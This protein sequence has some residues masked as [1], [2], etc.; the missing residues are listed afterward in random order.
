MIMTGSGLNSDDRNHG[1]VARGRSRAT[2]ITVS[3]RE[4]NGDNVRGRSLFRGGRPSEAPQSC[5]DVVGSDKVNS[6]SYSNSSNK[7]NPTVRATELSSIRMKVERMN[8]K[9]SVRCASPAS[10]AR[11]PSRHGSMCGGDMK[12]VGS[13]SSLNSVHTAHSSHGVRSRQGSINSVH[14]VNLYDDGIAGGS[15]SLYPGHRRSVFEANQRDKDKIAY[16]NGLNQGRRSI[17]FA[18][19]N[20]EDYTYASRLYNP[21]PVVEEKQPVF[22]PAYLA[23]DY[24]KN[25]FQPAKRPVLGRRSNTTSSGFEE[26]PRSKLNRVFSHADNPMFRKGSEYDSDNDDG[27]DDNDNENDDND[28]DNN[29]TDSGILVDVESIQKQL[30]QMQ[31]SSSTDAD[32]RTNYGGNA[33]RTQ[34]SQYA[35]RMKQQTESG[36]STGD[37]AAFGYG[38]Y[39]N[40][41]LIATRRQHEQTAQALLQLSVQGLRPFVASVERTQNVLRKTTSTKNGSNMKM[42][43]KMDMA[44][45]MKSALSHL[46]KAALHQHGLSTT[47]SALG[48]T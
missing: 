7:E 1:Q 27:T 2:H 48:T 23:S 35:M 37:T 39:V 26:I 5:S 25:A 4:E 24:T 32:G 43:M 15:G 3:S 9:T 13:T 8:S 31:L 21:N 30:S 36:V 22:R 29:S 11:I 17:D 44:A 34:Q 40:A 16:L 45:N 46:W 12:R 33:M 28:D 19:T 42:D 20:G 41:Q 18:N 10:V 14:S 38:Q 47:V 6:N